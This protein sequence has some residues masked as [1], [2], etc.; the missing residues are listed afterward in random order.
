MARRISAGRPR[1]AMPGNT[2]LKIPSRAVT[3]CELGRDFSIVLDMV[4]TA[5]DI[6]LKTLI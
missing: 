4:S 1:Q 5:G 2:A 6:E 3:C